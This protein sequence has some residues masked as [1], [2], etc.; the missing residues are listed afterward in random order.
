MFGYATI[1]RS[2]SKGMS[3]FSMEMCRY[4]RVP[5]SIAEEI[6]IARRKKKEAEARS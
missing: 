4:A 5:Q 1:L 3:T 6:I 2:L